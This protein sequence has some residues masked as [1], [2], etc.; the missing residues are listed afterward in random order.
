M[1]VIFNMYSIKCFGHRNE[2]RT[3]VDHF[4]LASISQ[5]NE[6]SETSQ[7]LTCLE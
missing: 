5:K 7:Q 3:A 2:T 6:Y 1:R 4:F